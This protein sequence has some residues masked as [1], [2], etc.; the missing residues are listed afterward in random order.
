MKVHAREGK[1]HF[2]MFS[3]R[4]F[5]PPRV[6]GT[7]SQIP[8]IPAIQTPQLQLPIFSKDFKFSGYQPIDNPFENHKPQGNENSHFTPSGHHQPNQYSDNKL[9][10]PSQG[11]LADHNSNWSRQ[12]EK[13]GFVK[14][15]AAMHEFTRQSDSPMSNISNVGGEYSRTIADLTTALTQAMNERSTLLAENASLKEKVHVYEERLNQVDTKFQAMMSRVSALESQKPQSRPIPQASD[16]SPKSPHSVRSV[17]SSSRPRSVS[18]TS[19]TS[20]LSIARADPPARSASVEREPRSGLSQPPIRSVAIAAR[21]K[22]SQVTRRSVSPARVSSANAPAAAVPPI[23]RVSSPV[24]RYEAHIFLNDR[25]VAKA[26]LSPSLSQD[27]P[28]LYVI[29]SELKPPMTFFPEDGQP[30]SSPFRGISISIVGTNTRLKKTSTIFKSHS[31]HVISPPVNDSDKYF[32]HS[33]WL[34]G[35][36]ASVVGGVRIF[37]RSEA[38]GICLYAMSLKYWFPET[39]GSAAPNFTKDHWRELLKLLGLL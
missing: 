5:L 24:I 7:F 35:P 9:L 32:S 3:S 11:V 2:S 10:Q 34:S 38:G 23:N 6:D 28:F 16:N 36:E 25:I 27:G 12:P 13:P 21:N 8:G 39:S 17:P 29:Q 19:R 31:S 22:I 30:P 4:E 33:C 26:Q 37:Y 18:A 1:F 20:R 15:R 14:P